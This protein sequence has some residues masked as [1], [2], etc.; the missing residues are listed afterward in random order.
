MLF[1]RTSRCIKIFFLLKLMPIGIGYL[2]E[3]KSTLNFQNYFSLEDKVSIIVA[4]VS[5]NQYKAKD[6]STF[7]WRAKQLSHHCKTEYAVVTTGK[8]LLEIIESFTKQKKN[9]YRVVIHAHGDEYGI[10]FKDNQGVYLDTIRSSSKLSKQYGGGA[11]QVWLSDWAKLIQSQ[12]KRLDKQALF[13]FLSCK[14]QAFAYNFTQLTGIASIG[15]RSTF[16]PIVRNYRETGVYQSQSGF[17]YNRPVKFQAQEGQFSI[18]IQE[19]GSI[20]HPD[21]YLQ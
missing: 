9:L 21:A 8:R 4:G 17:C 15:C 3:I 16:E 19:L 7:K 12:R 1:T 14:S 6:D 11:S 20:L 13:I 18:E 10:F 5:T 2:N